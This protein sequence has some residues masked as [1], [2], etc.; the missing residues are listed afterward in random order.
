LPLSPWDS[1]GDK[2]QVPALPQRCAIHFLPTREAV[3]V[4]G[5]D[6]A[7]LGECYPDRAQFVVAVEPSSQRGGIVGESRAIRRDRPLRVR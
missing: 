2:P 5:G 3:E 7:F 6:A 4:V 1:A